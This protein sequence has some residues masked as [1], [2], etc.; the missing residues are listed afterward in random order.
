MSRRILPRAFTVD[1]EDFILNPGEI[2]FDQDLD[3]VR[4]GDGVTPGGISFLPGSSATSTVQV[5]KVPLFFSVDGSGIPGVN[6]PQQGMIWQQPGGTT[7]GADVQGVRIQRIANYTGGADGFVNSGLWVYTQAGVDTTAYEW[8]ALCRMD[9]Y[10][11]GASQNNALY[12]QSNKHGIGGTWGATI[13]LR[14]KT[15]TENPT[16]PSIALE[17][18]MFGKGTDNNNQR[19]GV[20]VVF[21]D[22]LI[23]GGSGTQGQGF[24]GVRVG[25]YFGGAANG[26]VK[27]AFTVEGVTFDVGYDTAHGTMASG[28]A[29]IRMAAL[30]ILSFTEPVDRWFRYESFQLTYGIGAQG[31]HTSPFAIRDDGTVYAEKFQTFLSTPASS[32][33]TAAAGEIKADSNYIYIATGVNTWK[34]AALSS[35]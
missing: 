32:S 1:L 19:G 17:V 22:P 2:V 5:D 15:G 31:S 10:A 23:G 29:G 34:R 20:D 24:F 27:R 13:E 9:N 3:A 8:A 25:A 30:Q 26:Y 6:I 12:V 16:K 14:E 21:G 33:A 4:V 35:F 11:V 7:T 28:G 18:D